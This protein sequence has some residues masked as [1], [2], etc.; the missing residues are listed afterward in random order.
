M[1]KRFYGTAVCSISLNT[2]QIILNGQVLIPTDIS[3]N[4]PSQRESNI[5]TFAI[6]LLTPKTDA[7]KATLNLIYA[8]APTKYG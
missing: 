2:Y 6:S 4:H 1:F 5:N 3:I 7:L 8:Y